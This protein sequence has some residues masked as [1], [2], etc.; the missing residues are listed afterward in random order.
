MLCFNII[1]KKKTLHFSYEKQIC[2]FSRI[3]FGSFLNLDQK[4]KK[5]S[6]FILTD[7][8]LS[9]LRSYRVTNFM[10]WPKFV[11]EEKKIATDPT[12]ILARP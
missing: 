7:L 4:Y 1:T 11:M 9:G 8:V 2:E 10:K 12:P 6:L 5:L 3:G